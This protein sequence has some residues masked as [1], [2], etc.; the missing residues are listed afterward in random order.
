MYRI[1]LYKGYY[2]SKNRYFVSQNKSEHY[3]WFTEFLDGVFDYISLS[4]SDLRFN[5]GTLIL[6]I[7]EFKEIK[8]NQ[9]IFLNPQLYNY[10]LIYDYDNANN[11]KRRFYIQNYYYFVKS[12][13]TI[14]NAFHL[15]LELDYF[16]TY[17]DTFK[18]FNF[19]VSR[20]NMKLGTGLYDPIQLTSTSPVYEYLDYSMAT[21]EKAE[22]TNSL[23][24]YDGLSIV[25]SL[26]FNI[27]QNR[28]GNVA[29]T[30]LFAINLYD[31]KKAYCDIGADPNEKLTRS[32]I[33]PI[34]LA[35]AFVSGINK[36]NAVGI[37]GGNDCEVLKA[38]LID[39]EKITLAHE[40]LAG[41]ISANPYN[42][43]SYGVVYAVRPL[44][45]ERLFHFN[46]KT[47]YKYYLGTKT[48]GLPLIK[49]TEN[50]TDEKLLYIYRFGITDV[51]V[52]VKYGEEEMDITD[53][54]EVELTTNEGE[55]SGIRSISNAL[56]LG[57]GT[58]TS[59][60]ANTSIIK[61][62]GGEM[63]G[64]LAGTS[65]ILSTINNTFDN[66]NQKYLGNIK[67]NGEGISNFYYKLQDF[68]NDV[69]T[70]LKRPVSY[71]PYVI[72]SYKSLIDEEANA[73]LNGVAT[74][75]TYFDENFIS[76]LVYGGYTP[77]QEKNENDPI[78]IKCDCEISNIPYEAIEII[79]NIFNNGV[80]L[81]ATHGIL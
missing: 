33:N 25:F 74:N 66:I 65:G 53:Q 81:Y 3:G 27:T 19:N 36:V 17:Y 24:R 47:N 5:N 77:I 62:A 71:N 1:K 44:R 50:Y 58:A 69:N 30:R 61:K 23:L 52:L 79:K 63:L 29:T 10:V 6:N 28:F 72:T 40:G 35:T 51:Q 4:T 70:N 75:Y 78:Y 2:G 56:S 22:A 48:K 11:I 16:S 37:Y 20:S 49:T 80:Y 73:R 31:L 39:T 7:D 9:T 12:I 42:L 14:G 46:K 45:T 15:E 32:K 38:Y 43:D 59:L 67:G 18:A 54:F 13:K 60:I 41:V 26:N 8:N 34:D 64:T 68:T 76:Q 21:T 57:I 55:I